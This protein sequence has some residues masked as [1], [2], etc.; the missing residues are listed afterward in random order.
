M[1]FHITDSYGTSQRT[2][3]LRGAMEWL[4]YCSPVAYVHNVF[5]YCVASRV[6]RGQA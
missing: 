4:P 5:G 6:Y 3:T 1:L 2:W